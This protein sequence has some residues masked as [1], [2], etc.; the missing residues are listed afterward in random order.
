[1]SPSDIITESAAVIGACIYPNIE[2]FYAAAPP[3][4]R[5]RSEEFHF[6]G[7]REGSGRLIYVENTSE[8][9]FVTDTTG[10][11]VVLGTADRRAD[12]LALAADFYGLDIFGS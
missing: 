7:P 9:V 1:M 8:V 6:C 5:R 3:A 4:Q 10:E 12:F 11:V 2:E